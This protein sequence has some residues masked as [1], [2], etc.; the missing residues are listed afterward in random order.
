MDGLQN[1]QRNKAFQEAQLNEKIA[2]KARLERYAEEVKA[3]EAR[4]EPLPNIIRNHQY[5]LKS[6]HQQMN[7]LSVQIMCHQWRI[8]EINVKLQ[9]FQR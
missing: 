6:T 8:D 9:K 4:G 2:R 7:E 1:Y 5:E 3:M